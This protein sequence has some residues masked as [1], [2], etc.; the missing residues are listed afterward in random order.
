[1]SKKKRT[2]NDKYPKNG[3]KQIRV[4][5]EIWDELIEL[6]DLDGRSVKEYIARVLVGHVKNGRKDNA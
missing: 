5:E 6:A 2:Y 1:M 4:P 3:H